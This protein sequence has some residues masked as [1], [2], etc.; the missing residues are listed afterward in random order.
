VALDTAGTKPAEKVTKY[1]K[2]HQ[3]AVRWVETAKSSQK[4]SNKQRLIP[5]RD[6]LTDCA[7]PPA[8]WLQ[9]RLGRLRGQIEN[10][11][12]AGT[13]TGSSKIATTRLQPAEAALIFTGKQLTKNPEFG[14][15]SKLCS[16]SM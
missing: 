8:E 13:R 2:V 7:L 14:N 15:N 16:F 10:R 5:K 9:Q 6:C 4:K 12:L 3:T 1:G 11:G